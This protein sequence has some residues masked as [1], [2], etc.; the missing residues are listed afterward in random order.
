ML[1][2]SSIS[3]TRPNYPRKDRYLCQTAR[4]LAARAARSFRAKPSIGHL[5]TT[6]QLEPAACS[7]TIRFWSSCSASLSSPG[8][9]F[10]LLFFILSFTKPRLSL[11]PSG[12]HSL[13]PCLASCLSL[14][15]CCSAFLFP[16][17]PSVHIPTRF[18]MVAPF[19]YVHTP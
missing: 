12:V 11:L 3:A 18:L 8:T 13:F 14:T 15:L 5:H 7:P 4:R 17:F 6:L 9:L 2:S 10:P 1:Q 16:F 19:H